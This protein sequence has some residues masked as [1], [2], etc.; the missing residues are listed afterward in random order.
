[1]CLCVR[2]NNFS[3]AFNSIGLNEFVSIKTTAAKENR[4]NCCLCCLASLCNYVQKM[5]FWLPWNQ[6]RLL[7]G[8]NFKNLSILQL[9]Q[10]NLGNFITLSCKINMNSNSNST[11]TSKR[12]SARLHCIHAISIH[13]VWCTFE[14]CRI[15]IVNCCQQVCKCVMR[16]I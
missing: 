7:I 13:R 9:V 2:S 16:N 12:V 14:F 1:M 10:K 3:T 5:R 8:S 4:F 15:S 6:Q 11:S